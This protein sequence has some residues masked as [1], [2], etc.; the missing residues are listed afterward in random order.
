M[1]YFEQI[2]CASLMDC[3]RYGVAN[4]NGIFLV[5]AQCVPNL[6]VQENKAAMLLFFFISLSSSPFCSPWRDC[7]RVIK[8]INDER[9][10]IGEG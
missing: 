4:I 10:F 6:G 1:V 9:W 3:S 8:I 7:P 2:M 5:R